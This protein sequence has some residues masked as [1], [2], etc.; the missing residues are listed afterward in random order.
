MRYWNLL[1]LTFS[2]L[3]INCDDKNKDAFFMLYN[4]IDIAR[5]E[6]IVI[7]K[8]QIKEKLPAF[9]ES[10][11][12]IFKDSLG[13][14]FPY[15][16][17]DMDQDGIWDEAALVVNFEALETKRLMIYAFAKAESPQYEKKTDVH[18][19]VGKA[20]PEA[21]EEQIYTRSYDPRD[22]DSLF[23][24][25]EG[26]A[27]EN[28]KVGFRMYFDPRNG[29]DIF[30]KTTEEPT[31]HQQGLTT[32]YHE[33]ADWGMDILKVGNSLGAGAIAFKHQDSLYRLTGWN[34]TRFEAITEGPARAIFR[35]TYLDEFI[36]D[37]SYH[38]VHTITIEK[39]DWFYK[40]DVELHGTN[41]GIELY[42]GIVNLKENKLK[43]YNSDEGVDVLYSFGKQSENDDHLGMAI[44]TAQSLTAYL[45]APS[46]GTGI[47]NTYLLNLQEGKNHS[48]YF[49]S[50]WEAS[51][52]QFK[53]IE[54]FEKL[55]EQSTKMINSPIT[56]Q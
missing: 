46:E 42:T 37:K 47:T 39:G 3:F 43:F 12:L 44:I 35:M 48:F 32:N 21:S 17:D 22:K 54:G 27:W 5:T 15:Q 24:Q 23:F 11:I 13:T 51:D 26:P 4:E 31:L 38:I 53:T 36:G 45:D 30:G 25:M 1:L 29:I 6:V 16:L 19:G 2:I 20:K 28:D 18:F 56:I 7:S 55:L 40:S 50:G 49:M 14:E 9:D 10:Q 41:D 33:K 34:G 52:T 8:K